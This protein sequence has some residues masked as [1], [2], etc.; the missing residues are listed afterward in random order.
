MSSMGSP[1]FNRLLKL[2]ISNVDILSIALGGSWSR[3]TNRPDSDYDLFCVIKDDHF[4]SFKET[5]SYFVESNI[6]DI[7]VFVEMYYL[8]NWGYLFK[9]IDTEGIFYDLSIIPSNR[10]NEISIRSTNIL[11]KDTG[12]LYKNEIAKADDSRFNPDHRL[13]LSE[14][15]INKAFYINACRFV[16]SYY[17]NDYW[18]MIRYL[19]KMRINFLM[20]A[21][22]VRRAHTV[23]INIP[24]TNI[25]IDCAD[26]T[27]RQN[28]VIDG[29]TEALA[30]TGKYLMTEYQK[31]LG[32]DLAMDTLIKLFDLSDRF[33]PPELDA[34]TR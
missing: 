30:N 32:D 1:I 21:R 29:T 10:I 14:G 20:R 26:L 8:E 27:L 19:E 4:L 7:L 17:R 34:N 25:E 5:F 18:L 28:Y 13:V 31:T 3:N 12:N 22:T 33:R 16:K 2:L 6:S 11:Y 24:E 23:S 15:P 9:G